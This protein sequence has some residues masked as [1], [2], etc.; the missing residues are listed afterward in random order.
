MRLKITP[1]NAPMHCKRTEKKE[2]YGG[3]NSSLLDVQKFSRDLCE[4]ERYDFL[5]ARE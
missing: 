2:K 1:D 4:F 5:Y 3:L